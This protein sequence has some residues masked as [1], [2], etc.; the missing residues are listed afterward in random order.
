MKQKQDLFTQ[1]PILKTEEISEIS[2]DQLTD[3]QSDLSAVW[4]HTAKTFLCD[5]YAETS[6]ISSNSIQ[7]YGENI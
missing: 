1:N 4:T 6:F 7:K 2:R 3:I 5:N